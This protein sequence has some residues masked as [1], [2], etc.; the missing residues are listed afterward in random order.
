MGG[1]ETVTTRGF[2]ERCQGALTLPLL[3]FPATDP[4]AQAEKV[5]Q[6]RGLLSVALAQAGS[7]LQGCL[8]SFKACGKRKLHPN[9]RSLSQA[10]AGWAGPDIAHK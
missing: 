6:A 1:C 8:C 4:H 7:Y 3:T 10:R 2:P 9:L 5:K